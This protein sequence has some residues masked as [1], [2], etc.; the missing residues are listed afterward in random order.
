MLRLLPGLL[1]NKAVYMAAVKLHRCA[2]NQ[3]LCV[4]SYVQLCKK[5]QDLGPRHE[6]FQLV[7]Y[8]ILLQLPRLST[9]GLLTLHL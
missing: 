7:L 2:N 3:Q 5:E 6:P 1:C 9:P 8:H 4:H